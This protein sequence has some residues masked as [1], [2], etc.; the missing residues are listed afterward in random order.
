MLERV[1]LV[2]NDV[3]NQTSTVSWHQVLHDIMTYCNFDLT[4]D[5]SHT[6]FPLLYEQIYLHARKFNAGGSS[7]QEPDLKRFIGSI[8]NTGKINEIHRRIVEGCGSS[9]ITT[10]YDY[11]LEVALAGGTP[12]C[13]NQGF[14]T[15][16]KYS[17]FRHTVNGK[18]RVW[19]IHGESGSPE[20]INLGFEHYGG[21]LQHL[22]NYLTGTAEYGRKLPYRFSIK[23]ALGQDSTDALSWVDLLF[24]CEIH[25]LGLALDF[26]EYDLWWLFSSRARMFDKLGHRPN[27]VYYHTPRQYFNQQK[28]D[29][30]GSLHIITRVHEGS[31]LDYYRMVLG[32]LG[33]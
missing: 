9:L 7:L 17:V 4:I 16:K 3:N 14:I 25:I 6:P 29:V 28:C 8:V 13:R 1:F 10:N 18:V 12:V 11:N 22:R 30:M 2:G 5:T 27:P 20:S 21:Q 19:H 15:E 31:G 33:A 26:Q 23:N 24:T 32:S